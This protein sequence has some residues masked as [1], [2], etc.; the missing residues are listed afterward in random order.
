MQTVKHVSPSRRS[1][2][3]R[4]ALSLAALTICLALTSGKLLAQ[5]NDTLRP[6]AVVNDEV[7]SVLDLVMRTRLAILGSGV[8]DTPD[9]RRKIARQVLLRLIDERL[10]MQEAKRLS[11]EV[12]D[13]RVKEALEQLADQNNMNGQQF[14]QALRN[15]QILPSALL[16]Q[17]R[18][19]L[20]WQDLIQTS[21]R[22]EVEIRPQEIDAVVERITGGGD[23]HQYRV[24]EIFLVVPDA[25]QEDEIWQNAR[26]LVEEA[27]GGAN[28]SG[29]ARQ[30][31]ES[32]SANLGGDL[33]WVAGGQLQEELDQALK[34]MSP[35]EISDPIRTIT[36][37]N[38]LLLRDIQET[39]AETIDR[40]EIEETLAKE[41][42][43]Q[44]A[45]RRLQELRR[46]ASIDIRV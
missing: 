22:R 17:I 44:L 19:E 43:D 26:R 25:I 30:F 23:H 5:T 31:S 37:F 4:A 46:S 24:A 32:G 11:I 40:A 7:V 1:L 2:F 28:F 33:G 12:P 39:T 34:N 14:L 18:V 8:E 9:I 42:L 41:R 21:L 13:S 10:Q 45:Q 6:A 27:R 35:G 20:T 36:G 16:S 29:L 3:V 38:I 15:L